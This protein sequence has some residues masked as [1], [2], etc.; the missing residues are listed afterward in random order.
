[1]HEKEDISKS[2]VMVP[3][4]LYRYLRKDKMVKVK[5]ILTTTR[6]QQTQ[7]EATT[8]IPR[9]WM[10]MPI[11]QAYFP[12]Q[13]QILQIGAPSCNPIDCKDY[14]I[15]SGLLSWILKLFPIDE[16][17]STFRFV[18]ELTLKPWEFILHSQ[19]LNWRK[20]HSLHSRRILRLLPH[21]IWLCTHVTNRLLQY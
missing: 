18:K 11:I 7:W 13:H 15:T 6:Q 2:L 19:F 1:M 17:F 9:H 16:W 10:G 14:R 8:Q 5:A 21:V 20:P 4:L 12:R 3:C